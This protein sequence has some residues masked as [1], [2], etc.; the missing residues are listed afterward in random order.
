MARDAGYTVVDPATVLLTHLTEIIKQ[1]G[2]NLLTRAETERLVNRV[3]Q[4]Q[5]SLIEELIPKILSLGDVQKVL[6]NLLRERVPIRNMEGILEVLADVGGRNKEPDYLTE[7]VRERLGP[8]I[9]QALA[10]AEGELFVLT[11]DPAVEQAVTGA[12]RS[13]EDKAA[14]VLEPRM[15]EQ[16][17]RRLAAE[18]ERMMSNNLMPVLLC[19]PT[20]RR[21]VRRFTERMM[22]QLSVLSLTEIPNNVGLKAFGMIAV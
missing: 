17:L 11:L 2:P 10:N 18:V 15:A 5:A 16:L 12:I 14:L 19:S 1:Q 4:Q 22:P 6:Q 7:Q 21:H 13:I 8:T 20:L 9:C 3:R